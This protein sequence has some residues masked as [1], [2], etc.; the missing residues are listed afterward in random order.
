MSESSRPVGGM[1]AVR[2]RPDRFAGISTPS[3][4]ST[5]GAVS[6]MLTSSSSVLAG[7]IPGPATI[8]GM[9]RFSGTFRKWLVP[10]PPWSAVIST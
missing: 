9:S 1:S 4:Q 7:G 3:S 6:A 5:V 2:A 8:H 10:S